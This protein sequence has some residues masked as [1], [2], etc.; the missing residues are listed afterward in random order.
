MIDKKKEITAF[1]D[2]DGKDYIKYKYKAGLR[3]YMSVRHENM[4]D[5]ID[6]FV[7]KNGLENF[8]VLDAG[9]GPGL[10]LC[11]LIKRGFKV[12]GLDRSEGMLKIA[13]GNNNS[14]DSH[15]CFK[16]I[17]GDIEKLPFKSG[18]F[19]LVCSAGV[20]E[21]LNYDSKVLSEFRRI[22]KDDGFL[23]ISV[24]NKYAYNLIFDSILE[25]FKNTQFFFEMLTYI[26]VNL[27]GL[28]RIKRRHFIIRKHHPLK[29]KKEM[30]HNSFRIVHKRFFFLNLFP[31]PFYM[32]ARRLNDQ[33]SLKWDKLILSK[34]FFFGEGFMV[35][36]KKINK[37]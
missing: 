37:K 26:K 20:I 15:H 7:L 24:T 19:N 34:R 32:L 22:I 28:G 11:D 25:F 16:L 10:F 4:L 6:E 9:C 18:T 2:E 1:F 17:K 33:I 5:T 31:Y 36:A 27:F 3:T 29:F 35:L 14:L 30:E 12:I 21:Y 23:L 8:L 13:K